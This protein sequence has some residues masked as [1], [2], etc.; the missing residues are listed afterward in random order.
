M[1]YK[2]EVFSGYFRRSLA[3][4]RGRTVGTFDTIAT[5]DDWIAAPIVPSKIESA[6]AD[7]LAAELAACGPSAA[8]KA[9]G[10][11][12]GRVLRQV[13]QCLVM[14]LAERDIAHSAPLA[15]VCE[16]MTAFAA[17]STRIALRQAADELLAQFGRP[18]D[19]EGQPQDLLAVGMGKGGANELNV[20][21]DL[22]LVFVFREQGETEGVGTDTGA[23][24]P[25]SLI[26]SAEFMHRLARRTINLLSEATA[27][28]FV[29]RVDTR[30]RPNGESGPLVVTL[31]MLENYFYSQGREWERFAWLKGRVIADSGITSPEACA[32]DEQSLTSI[33]TPFVFR[34]YF[35]FRAFGALRDLHHLIRAEVAK[36]D[37]RNAGTIDVKLGRGGIREVEFTA[38]LFQVVRG[39]RDPG[40]RDR[41]TLATLAS[42]S[43]RGILPQI[44]ATALADAYTLLRR[45]EHALQYREDAQTHRLSSDPEERQAIAQ[46]LGMTLEA[47]G[48][49]LEDARNAVQR[50]FDGLLSTTDDASVPRAGVAGEGQ[51]PP[52]EALRLRLDALRGSARYR[53]AR[54]ETRA[55]LE[56]LL[57]RAFAEHTDEAALSRLIDLIETVIG[58]P[59]YL[60]L[61]S[62]F[63]MAQARVMQLLGRAKWAADYLIQ[64]PIVLDE[65]LDGQ[66]FEQSDSA[67]WEAGLRASLAVAKLDDGTPDIEHQ[68]DIMRESH[69]AQVFRLLAQDL[70][71]LHTVERISDH[72]SELADRVL[73]IT[74]DQV[75]PLVR[76]RHRD[77]PRFAVIA[78]GRLGGK[79]LGYASDLDLVYLYDDEHENAQVAYAQLAQRLSTWLSSRTAAGQLFEV[80]LRLRPNGDAGLVVSSLNGFRSYERESAWVWEHQALTRARFAAGDAAIGAAFEEERRAI[81]SRERDVDELR[82]EV[83]SMRK[84]MHDGHPNRSEL[85][86]LKHD[87]GGMVDIEF[88]VQTLVL[89][90]SH[91]YP[92]LL[93]NV[94]NIALLGRAGKAGLI[95]AGLAQRV[96]DAY[97]TF[98]QLQHSLRLNDVRYARVEPDS[99]AAFRDD[100]RRLWRGTFGD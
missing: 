98:R 41:R 9:R 13:R 97:R 58:R 89:A 17:A 24:R 56:N 81:L 66:L 14:A 29:F 16:A 91:R 54:E 43:E 94:G 83:I 93:D 100:V 31:P 26:A 99:V 47:F 19:A 71:G 75:W 70:E 68:M 42:L 12:T 84:R 57:A 60:A 69:H 46:M 51:A 48:L 86:D 30:L 90:H 61:L 44:D 80:D 35:D 3:A 15:E 55:S 64:H 7:A 63:P 74:L 32:R 77:S 59:A 6:L 10:E 82:R 50:V 67:V 87:D 1:G 88:I 5:L 62:E 21:S 8:P 2:A 72:L 96:S 65:L 22:D 78:Y 18:L 27:D 28:G 73:S 52:A 40:L 4:I 92:G 20:S 36:R 39:G 25:A 95:D 85:F 33:V 45:A 23:P 37:A 49:A 53:S 34:R 38:Q 76:S 79:E 11:A